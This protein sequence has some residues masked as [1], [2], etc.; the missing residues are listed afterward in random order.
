MKKGFTLLE[1]IVVIIIIGILATLGFTQYSLIV[2]KG[3]TAE[4]R[5]LLSTVRTAEVAYLLENGTY[6]QTLSALSVNVPTACDTNHYYYYGIIFGTG[7]CPGASYT[8]YAWRCTT[9]GKPPQGPS[10]YT[11][12]VCMD[13][14]TW[15]SDAPY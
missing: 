5:A 15:S 1:L 4:A 3:R 14:G 9:G 10:S 2:E 11:V 12:A 13:T 8:A 6:T 7:R